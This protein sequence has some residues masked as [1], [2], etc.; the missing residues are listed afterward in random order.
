MLAIRGKKRE[1]C[2]KGIPEATPQLAEHLQH[3]QATSPSWLYVLLILVYL[4]T[5]YMFISYETHYST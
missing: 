4:W 3:A 2:E 1:R 5:K